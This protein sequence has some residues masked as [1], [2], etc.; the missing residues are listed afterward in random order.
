MGVGTFAVINILLTASAAFAAEPMAPSDIQATFFNGQPFSASTPSGTQF[1]MTFTPD[2][3]MTREPLAHTGYKNNGT[4]KLTAKG[5][6]TSWSR[7]KATCYTI[8][9]RGENKWSVQQ[10]VTTIA[11]TIAM[12]SK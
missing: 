6:C 2:G 5:F 10:A 12:W 3:K 11:T 4:W 9:P 1:K 7:S 8:I